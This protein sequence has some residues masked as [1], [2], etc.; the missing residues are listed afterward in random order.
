MQL[1]LKINNVV[2]FF[3]CLLL[4]GMIILIDYYIFW[5]TINYIKIQYLLL[6]L[7]LLSGILTLIVLNSIMDLIKT[8]KKNATL[9]IMS[10][11]LFSLLLVTIVLGIFLVIPGF[12][13]TS[14]ALILYIPPVRKGIAFVLYKLHKNKIISLFSIFLYEHM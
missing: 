3:Y 1:L 8:I 2:L 11:T 12:V 10:Y 5:V 14:I 6:S 9:G 7:A 4:F 13:S